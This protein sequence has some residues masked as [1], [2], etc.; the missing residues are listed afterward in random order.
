MSKFLQ[1]LSVTAERGLTI[2][3]IG[4][5]GSGK[6]TL[7]NNL[8]GVEVYPEDYCES[9]HI[10]GLT[11]TTFKRDILGISVTIH[12][13]CGP[14]SDCSVESP[15]AHNIGSLF[16]CTN[17]GQFAIIYCF[18]L[19]E[20][21]MR[22]SLVQSLKRCNEMGLL[23]NKTVIA[24]TFA[25]ALPVARAVRQD[26]SYSQAKYFDERLTEWTNRLAA[27]LHEHF[28]VKK[29]SVPM[30]PTTDN[31]QEALPNQQLWYKPFWTCLLSTINKCNTSTP[32]VLH[33]ERA[34][35]CTE[36][37]TAIWKPE[38]AVDNHPT[39]TVREP[40]LQKEVFM[41]N[42]EGH[43][44]YESMNDRSKGNGSSTGRCNIMNVLT[45]CYNACF[46]FFTKCYRRCSRAC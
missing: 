34:I 15:S 46:N 3:V 4:D 2:L 18:K 37:A 8:L 6:S 22:N 33:P 45:D 13:T 1:Q 7:V 36:T 24:F 40:L 42:N 25:D 10:P 27:L 12:E 21:R 43:G 16:N 20:T 26:P 23:W 5:P 14:E 44:R 31:V 19:C 28:G 30:A 41:M 38:E 39:R 32:V 9:P 17:G 35:V 29:G 11:V